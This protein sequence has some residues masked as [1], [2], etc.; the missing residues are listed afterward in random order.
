MTLNTLL[1]LEILLLG[2]ET[3]PH[4][5]TLWVP[6]AFRRRDV[7]ESVYIKVK[8]LHVLP[9]GPPLRGRQTLQSFVWTFL[10]IW[11]TNHTLP[12]VSSAHL[13]FCELEF[14]PNPSKKKNSL[15]S[16]FYVFKMKN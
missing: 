13:R 9:D 15:L 10:V 16:D 4:S 8:P 5:R 7:V 3:P 2:L 12:P 6:K 14:I 1:Y 11:K